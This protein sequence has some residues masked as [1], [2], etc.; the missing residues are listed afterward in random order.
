MKAFSKLVDYMGNGW[1]YWNDLIKETKERLNLTIDVDALTVENLGKTYERPDPEDVYEEPDLVLPEAWQK[2]LETLRFT[3]RKGD[4]GTMEI[5]DEHGEPILNYENEFD[6][7][8]CYD[9]LSGMVFAI[10][11]WQIER[12]EPAMPEQ[13]PAQVPKPKKRKKKK[14]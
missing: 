13:L 9:I 5:F 3:E 1:L 12:P 11:Y 4:D 14:R 8:G 6:K 7:I 2:I 10:D